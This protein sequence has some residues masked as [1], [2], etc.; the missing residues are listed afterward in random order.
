MTDQE[1]SRIDVGTCSN[2][3]RTLRV[4]PNG[5]QKKMRL[6]CKCGHVNELFIDQA[7]LSRNPNQRA[8]VVLETHQ[9]EAVPLERL[10]D[11]PRLKSAQ[12]EQDELTAKVWKD[13][14]P[15]SR[16]RTDVIGVAITLYWSEQ[17]ARA[18]L[19]TLVE[20]VKVTEK[21]R[22]WS[23][24]LF[25]SGPGS[26]LG[27]PYFLILGYTQIACSG[28]VT[29]DTIEQLTHDLRSDNPIAA[30]G[31][32]EL[33]SRFKGNQWRSR[34]LLIERWV[35]LDVHDVKTFST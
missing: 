26:P 24:E 8:P 16:V 2:C 30:G 28:K 33:G 6:T 7:V 10:L 35:F 25:K 20:R 21:A 29:W 9:I 14:P 19:K 15:E 31:E 12:A 17:N 22:P 11:G 3:G 32:W 1:P 5:L 18:A 34:G 27:S 4:K 23:V 13:L